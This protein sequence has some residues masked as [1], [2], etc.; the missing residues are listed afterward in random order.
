MALRP[1]FMA[2]HEETAA[3]M[4]AHAEGE[5]RGFRRLRVVRHLEA[6]EVCRAIFGTLVATIDALR[7]LGRIEAEPMPQLADAVVTRIGRERRP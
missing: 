6:C 3:L 5:L 7:G 1:F 2:S 4:S